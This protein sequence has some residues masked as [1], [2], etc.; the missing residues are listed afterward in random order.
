MNHPK[1]FGVFDYLNS[2]FDRAA[3]EI[4]SAEKAFQDCDPYKSNL[5]EDQLEIITSH[6]EGLKQAIKKITNPL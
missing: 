2:V 6:H 1:D 5:T 4:T 3:Q